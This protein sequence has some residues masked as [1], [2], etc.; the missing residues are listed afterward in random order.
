MKQKP[1]RTKVSVCRNG[2]QFQTG[3]GSSVVIERFRSLADARQD[4]VFAGVMARDPTGLWAIRT[5]T[6]FAAT[7]RIPRSYMDE[8]I[9]VGQPDGKAARGRRGHQRPE[10][11]VV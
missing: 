7:L 2:A 6:E 1:F 10:L 3:S 9:K 11:P 8:K 4:L 5:P